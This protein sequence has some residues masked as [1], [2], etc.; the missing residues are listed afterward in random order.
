[1]DGAMSLNA[2]DAASV[3]QSSG[4]EMFAP[5]ITFSFTGASA[6]FAIVEQSA[7]LGTLAFAVALANMV[8]EK[9][10]QAKEKNRRAEHEKINARMAMIEDSIKDIGT[11]IDMILI[12]DSRDSRHNMPRVQPPRGDGGDAD[13]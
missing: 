10:N 7:T 4:N 13:S 6:V 1:M 8:W 11:R 2:I 12:A 5:W 3:D 9:L